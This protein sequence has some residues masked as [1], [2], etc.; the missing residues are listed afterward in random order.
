[1]IVAHVLAAA[2]FIGDQKLVESF[3]SSGGGANQTLLATCS[4]RPL[5]AAAATNGQ[6]ENRSNTYVLRNGAEKINHFSKYRPFS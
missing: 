1:M 2:A 4:I 6:I 5:Q 3:L